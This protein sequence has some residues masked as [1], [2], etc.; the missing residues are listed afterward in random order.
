MHPLNHVSVRHGFTTFAS[1]SR[2]SDLVIVGVLS[3]RKVFLLIF[4]CQFF[5]ALPIFSQTTNKDKDNQFRP[6][7][8]VE[9]PLYKQL[10]LTFDSDLRLGQFEKTRFA[11]PGAG[12]VY[13]QKVGRFVSIEPGYR[14][15][16]LQEFN[17]KSETENILFVNGKVKFNVRQFKI[18]QS[19]LFEYRFRRSGDAPRYRPSLKISHPVTVGKTKIDLFVS[20]EVYYE[21]KDRAWTRNRFKIGFSKNIGERASYEIYYMRQNDSYSR[22]GDLHVLGIKLKIETKRLFGEK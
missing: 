9:V 7:V 17:G 10:Y 13:K 11:R 19:N 21:W 20:D 6:E 3:N 18:S 1:I 4:L 12:L 14:Y 22:P 5:F 8:E 16:Y 2:I 15:R